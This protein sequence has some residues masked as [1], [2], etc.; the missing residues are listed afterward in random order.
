MPARSRWLTAVAIP[1]LLTGAA[2][3]HGSG[4]HAATIG[5]PSGDSSSA[6]PASTTGTSTTTISPAGVSTTSASSS[7]ADADPL[8]P[9]PAQAPLHYRKS[10]PTDPA[11]RA[12]YVAYAE[13]ADMVVRAYLDP[14]PND[15][16]ISQHATGQIRA[17]IVSTLRQF[18]SSG[19]ITTGPLTL[20][21]TVTSVVGS[22]A[23]VTDCADGRKERNYQH[24][25][26]TGEHGTMAATVYRLIRGPHG[27]AVAQAGTGPTGY[28][29]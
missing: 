20:K 17:R 16:A 19:T 12:V 1:V 5:S 2:C 26:A 9:G 23:S 14:N 8:P 22:A 24:G 15:P 21:P 27:W 11:K 7:A 4:V 29:D 13:Y 18:K 28:C 25:R 6:G 10:P 3:G